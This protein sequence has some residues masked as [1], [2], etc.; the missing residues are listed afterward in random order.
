MLRFAFLLSSILITSNFGWTQPTDP[1]EYAKWALPKF[2]NAKNNIPNS[3]PLT[4]DLITK[5]IDVFEYTINNNTKGG[6]PSSQLLSLN[7]EV[8]NAANKV[9]LENPDCMKIA[10]LYIEN[11]NNDSNSLTNSNESVSLKYDNNYFMGKYLPEEDNSNTISSNQRS[12]TSEEVKGKYLSIDDSD[13]SGIPD[14]YYP[15]DRDGANKALDQKIKYEVKQLFDEGNENRDWEKFIGNLFKDF[16]KAFSAGF[17]GLGSGLKN[18]IPQSAY[19]NLTN[20]ERVLNALSTLDDEQIKLELNLYVE[21][22]ESVGN[23]EAFN[24]LVKKLGIR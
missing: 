18:I 15:P 1:I 10:N 5:M 21:N 6:F 23:R 14:F 8:Q 20:A 11:N 7:N 22:A 16:L 13:G 19:V 17:K 4:K 12:L 2:N 9:A 3:C 24:L